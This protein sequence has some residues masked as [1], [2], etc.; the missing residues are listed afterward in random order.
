MFIHILEKLKKE[1][2]GEIAFN[3]VSEISRYHRIQ[4][5]PGLRESVRYAVNTMRNLS[6]DAEVHSYRAD[7]ETYSWSSHLFKEWNC[8]DAEL[9]LTEPVEHA[10]PLAL[11][12]ETKLSLIERSH[13]TPSGG[14]EGEVVALDKGENEAEYN[15]FDVRDKIVITGGDVARVYELAVNRHGARGIIYDG[16]RTYPPVRLEGDISDALERGRAGGWTG[17]EKPCFGF[18]LSPRKG[19]WLRNLVEEQRKK[20]KPVKVWA[21]VDSCFYSGNIENAVA[22]I[23]GETDEEVIIVAHICHPQGYANDNASGCGAA[24]EAMRAIQ[25]L[26]NTGDL[27]KPKRTIRLTL[28]PEMTGT[29]AWLAENEQCIPKMVAAIN[30]DMVGENQSLCGGPLTLVKTPDSTPSFTNALIEAILEEAKNEAKSISGASI[31]LL[32]LATTPF[33]GG[34]DHY[35]YSDPS[36]GVPCVG[37]A[38]WPDRFYHTSL[39]TIDKVDPEMLRKVAL[40]TATYAYFIANV[41]V[42]EAIWLAK[43]VVARLEGGLKASANKRFSK[44]L[45]VIERGT[46]E[47]ELENSI[48]EVKIKIDYDMGRGIEALKSVRKLTGNDHLY[49]AFEEHLVFKYEEA[50][51]GEKQLL[52]ET[53]VDYAKA[54]GLTL[55][56][57]ARKRILNE[58]EEKSAVTFPQ[59]IYR[60]PISIAGYTHRPW[61]SKLSPDEKDALWSL[62][63]KYPESSTLGTLAVFWADGRKSILE[64][65]DIIELETGRRNLEYIF[66]YFVFLKK[67]GLIELGQKGYSTQ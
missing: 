26:I 5:S 57:K 2:S 8:N 34:S 7:G 44:A 61:L 29:F 18:V 31:T 11:W 47:E 6:L 46:T 58:F 32:K 66:N 50:A 40:M 65:S 62:E 56:S 60:G 20:E 27:L 37:I 42:G 64:I 17:D 67:M 33:S 3:F 24:M 9:R 12:S 63:K 45:S 22:T 10:R 43:E 30:L 25:K 1:V 48:E 28:V 4:A 55:P 59:R 13:P 54:R 38:Q 16:M 41:G 21:K 53:L 14:Y 39:D 23:R 15:N 52:V 19:K 36:V 49:A 51:K 35:I